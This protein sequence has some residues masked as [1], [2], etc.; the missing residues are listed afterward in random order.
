MLFVLH[1]THEHRVANQTNKL[2]S[3][4]KKKKP[5][6]EVFYFEMT[7][8]NGGDLDAL[9]EAQGLFESKHIVVLKQT[10]EKAESREIVLPRLEKFADTENVFIVSENK[11]YAKY[12]KDVL[13]HAHQ[14]EEH[15][16]EEKGFVFDEFG[17]SSS[18]GN[19]DR[20]SLWLGYVKAV[21]SGMNTDSIL[22]T[23]HWSVRSLISAKKSNSQNESGLPP[24]S[25]SEFSTG[26]KKYT[27]EELLNMSRELI[28]IYHN[29]RRGMYK[30]DLALEKWI[31][32]G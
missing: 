6:A 29:A 30:Q 23:M 15:N 13:K 1:G 27:E 21:R 19:K 24:R 12:K 18:L 9:T 4:L 5:D 10:L 16:G 8:I 2:V 32:G 22:G 28:E 14:E 11:M 20:R 3:Q 25:Y 31:L 7:E 17:L 26:S